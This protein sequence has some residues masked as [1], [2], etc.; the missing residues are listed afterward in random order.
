MASCRHGWEHCA[1]C[2][3]GWPSPPAL[4]KLRV[5]WF[6][7]RRCAS[8]G[9]KVSKGVRVCEP[10]IARDFEA[11]ALFDTSDLFAL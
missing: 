1:F 8:C 7:P 6:R 11:L 10:C 9:K 4:P 2:F 3:V 5:P